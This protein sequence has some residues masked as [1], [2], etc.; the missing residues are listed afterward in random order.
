MSGRALVEQKCR[1]LL[2]ILR[3]FPSKKNAGRGRPFTGSPPTPGARSWRR[4]CASPLG[5]ALATRGERACWAFAVTRESY[6]LGPAGCSSSGRRTSRPSGTTGGRPST[7]PQRTVRRPPS[8]LRPSVSPL[9]HLAPTH[10][11]SLAPPPASPGGA[12][13]VRLL[14]EHGADPSAVGDDDVTPLHCATRGSL[15]HE[16]LSAAAAARA[17]GRGLAKLGLG[18]VFGAVAAEAPASP[19]S[20][21]G[22]ISGAGPGCALGGVCCR[23]QG[24]EPPRSASPPPRSR[25]D[26]GQFAGR[27]RGEDGRGRARGGRRR[28]F[29]GR[30]RADAGRASPWADGRS[31]GEFESC[32][33][34]GRRRCGPPTTSATTAR[35]GRCGCWAQ[36]AGEPARGAEPLPG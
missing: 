5:A 33:A 10:P 26:A 17:A 29:P 35:A 32:R 8:L 1:R 24:N 27:P 12:A 16:L 23:L 28:P 18:A 21:S 25:R 13:A 2:T 14:L 30:A 7:S 34:R 20:S 22:G 9:R 19:A 4:H 15:C 11:P 6:P 3:L 31:G 36:P